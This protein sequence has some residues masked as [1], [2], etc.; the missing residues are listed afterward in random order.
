MYVHTL[1]KCKKRKSSKKINQGNKE[2]G[3][4]EKREEKRILSKKH[5]NTES[6]SCIIILMT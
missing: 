6:L 3:M 2:G 5:T 4:G 1:K